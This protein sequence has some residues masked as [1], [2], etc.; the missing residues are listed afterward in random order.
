MED[1][2]SSKI[3]EKQAPTYQYAGL[4]ATEIR[5][6][7]IS[8]GKN[9]DPILC[10]LKTIELEKIKTTLL[11]FQALSY[12]WGSGPLCSQV[13]LNN[14]SSSDPKHQAQDTTTPSEDQTAHLPFRVRRS[15]HDALKRI[16]EE[17]T[18]TWIW[19]DAICID[20]NNNF[21]KGRQIPKMLD[22]YSNAW[23]VVVWLGE[24]QST[25]WTG[26]GADEITESALN[27]I[28]RILNLTALD[29]MLNPDYVD[30]NTLMAWKRFGDLIGASWFMRRWVWPPIMAFVI[31]ANV[32]FS[33]SR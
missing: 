22:I 25:S 11:N 6:L 27:L 33:H 14:A 12:A 7:R 2:P 26:P 9:K 16:R 15:L 24:S 3:V 21:E 29:S 4:A 10:T 13:F 28:S 18:H 5:L 17:D 32:A 19:V 23:N 8:P 1:I 30:D 31:H 20:Q